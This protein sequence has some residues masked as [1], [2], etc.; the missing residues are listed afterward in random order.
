M[1]DLK[2][3]ID[4]RA[5]EFVQTMFE[6]YNEKARR[7]GINFDQFSEAMRKSVLIE[8]FMIPKLKDAVK[9]YQLPPQ[10]SQEVL[11]GALEREKEKWDAV[12]ELEEINRH[13]SKK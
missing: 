7:Q 3:I 6:A 13:E 10:L 5:E 9:E 8:M 12:A 11:I 2:K 1:R 4:K